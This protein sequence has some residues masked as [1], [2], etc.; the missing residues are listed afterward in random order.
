MLLRHRR[1]GKSSGECDAD[2]RRPGSA[3]EGHEASR[4]VDVRSR[5]GIDVERESISEGDV[6]PIE[7]EFVSEG[8]ELTLTSKKQGQGQAGEAV[9]AEGRRIDPRV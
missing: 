2:V 9:S 8:G 6:V 7:A 5:D 3:I 4:P 1:A